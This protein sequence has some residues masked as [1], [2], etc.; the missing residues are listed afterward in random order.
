MKK[1]TESTSDKL[2][3]RLG[4]FFVVKKR[5]SILI[6]LFTIILGTLSYT[7]FLRREG[8]PAIEFPGAIITTPYFVNDKDI[9][10]N[11]VTSKLTNSILDI[12]EIETVQSTSTE[13]YSVIFVGFQEGSS[14]K[15][16]ARDIKENLAE[17]KDLP[18]FA[19]PEV[20]T[21]S[22]SSFIGDFD[23]VVAVG[24][25]DK[26]QAELQ[27]E[28]EL[29]A[30]EFGEVSV[31]AKSEVIKLIE[32]QVNPA[33]GEPF[34]FVAGF[35]RVGVK[36][37]EGDLNFTHT[38]LV[39]V[40][41]KG[42]N[43]G[44]LELSEGI[45]EKIDEMKE[46]G[47]LDGYTVERT[48]DMANSLA[49][50]IASLEES[51]FIGLITVLIVVFLLIN[52]RA[53]LVTA[54]FMPLVMASTFLVLY[55][56]GYTI[57]IITL[58]A[59]VLI[60]GLFVDDAT[61]IVEAID[62]QKK[63]GLKGLKAVKEAI[64]EVGVADVVGTT[65]VILV[66]TPLLFISG[67]LGKFIVQIPVT[68]ITAM[69]L[70]LIFALTLIAYL[71]NTIIKD[72]SENKKD[73]GIF[74]VLNK[75]SNGAGSYMN[76][77]GVK[78]SSF[79]SWYLN[80][81]KITYFVILPLIIISVLI[82]FIFAGKL[83]FS[84]F[85]QPKDSDTIN[86]QVTYNPETDLTEAENIAQ[87]VEAVIE[88]KYEEYVERISY[89]EGNN[90]R[91][92]IQVE[93]VSMHDRDVTSSDIVSGLQ[94]EY[95]KLA[96]ADIKVN[97]ESVGPPVEEYQFQMQVYEEDQTKLELVSNEVA[98]FINGKD[99]GDGIKVEKVRVFELDNVTKKDNKRYSAVKAKVSVENNTGALLELRQL[100]EDE[101]T[102]E[103][104]EELDVNTDALGFDLGQESENLESFYSA[105]FALLAALILIY[106]LLVIQFDS[107]SKPALIFTAIPLSFPGVFGG[108]Y[109][110]DN[111]FSFFVTIGIIALAGI[112][113]N[114]TIM[115]VDFA[116]Q[117]M[118]EGKNIK[119]AIS[120]AVERRFRAIITTSTTTVAGLLPLAFSDPFW[121]GLAFAMIFGLISS[122][123]LVLTLFPAV[124]YIIE[125][126][127]V[128]VKKFL[129]RR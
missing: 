2:L 29:I 20:Q 48:G 84:V 40:V 22:A 61:V 7:T 5:I 126:S 59:L 112:V 68:V 12:Q 19:Q 89:F 33:T 124:F 111:P 34:E 88:E 49:I 80:R 27:A 10:E 79:V 90:L 72:N 110:T 125:T 77:L 30:K 47:L 46:E 57:N 63:K 26:T 83:T 69:G 15:D 24:S 43:V 32:T 51:G 58:F 44:T 107:F 8:F 128:K 78:L 28:A 117:A 118:K 4:S 73:K 70:S 102:E 38:I 64:S 45:S 101:F 109:L 56:M 42:S 55:L 92:Y 86:I 37:L 62:Y 39:G 122:S 99:L 36:D 114:N 17:I 25:P 129:L 85:P 21:I 35:N 119:D 14:S 50:Q 76:K 120:Y 75:I 13:N 60:L 9:V 103:R 96:I 18:E 65:T 98:E 54:I 82:G 1:D 81:G 52:L 16:V 93:L 23:M 108:L 87:Q 105:I 95:N 71:S 100:I 116:T 53:A 3:V 74:S 123:I 113:V 11:D 121:E 94:D 115:L 106:I 66:F 41:K 127:R 6:L 97:K 104:L 31:V 91:A 67:I